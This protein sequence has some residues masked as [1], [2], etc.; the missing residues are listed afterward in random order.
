MFK[1]FKALKAKK[2]RSSKCQTTWL[3]VHLVKSKTS[4]LL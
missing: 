1:F 3:Y 4:L 2:F